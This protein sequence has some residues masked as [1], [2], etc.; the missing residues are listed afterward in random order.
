ME[1]ILIS[2]IVPVYNVELY[3]GRCIESILDQTYKNLQIILID[4]G[5]TDFSL[6]LCKGYRQLDDRILLIHQKNKGVSYARNVGIKHAVGEYI[7]FVDSDDTISP[8]MY[9]DMLIE[10]LEKDTN[11]CVT[12]KFY[13]DNVLYD[14]GDI[15]KEKITKMEGIKELLSLNFPTSLCNCLYQATLI[16][17]TYLNCNIHYFEDFEYQFRVLDKVTSISICKIPW[18]YYT[19]REDSANHQD[20]NDKVIS[21]L[22][23]ADIVNEKVK[24]EYKEYATLSKK[25]YSYFLKMTIGYLGKSSYV[26]DK[27]FKI[28]TKKSRKYIF[29]SLFQK[30]ITIFMK[31]YIFLCIFDAKIFWKLYRYAKKNS[32][33]VF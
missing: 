6:E 23:I 22:K 9:E 18:Y 26:E 5:S 16:K 10:I 27:Y 13:Y 8:T 19:K 31:I 33:F 28:I 1:D 4:D 2:I 30:D 21:C 14:N 17:Q 3:I 24:R 29:A 12:T 25:L 32:R 11:M 7:G 15:S 20:M